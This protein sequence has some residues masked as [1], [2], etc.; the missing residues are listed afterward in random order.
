MLRRDSRLCCFRCSS[1]S[2]FQAFSKRLFDQRIVLF[3]TSVGV[4]RRRCIWFSG[5][6][7]HGG[8]GD[9]GAGA[10][11]S[12]SKRFCRN[13]FLSSW[14]DGWGDDAFSSWPIELLILMF[15]PTRVPNKANVG[16]QTCQGGIDERR[17]VKEVI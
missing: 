9:S 10:A 7:V 4:S 15:I 14:V 17:Q 2:S 3:W 1:H 13:C 11:R 12:Y 8:H 5:S 6:S 16:L